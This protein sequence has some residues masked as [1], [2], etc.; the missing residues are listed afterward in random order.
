MTDGIY[1]HK[2]GGGSRYVSSGNDG[3][4]FSEAE[5]PYIKATML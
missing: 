4:R 3:K 5:T 1:D 2:C